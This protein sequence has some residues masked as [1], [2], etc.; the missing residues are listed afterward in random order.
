M[1][2]IQR[3]RVLLAAWKKTRLPK[4][5]QEVEYLESTGTQRIRLGNSVPTSK[6]KFY[7]KL[8]P[9]RLHGGSN[10]KYNGIMGANS[11]PQVGFYAGGWT[12]GI[13]HSAIP[14]PP[15]VGQIY[16]IVYSKDFDGS[17]WVDGYDTTIKRTGN[18][19]LNL[20]WVESQSTNVFVKLYHAWAISN[21]DE[22]L[23]D[24]IPCY[25]KA[26]NKPGLFDLINNT[27]YTNNQTGE[28]I[29]GPNV[30]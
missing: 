5:F 13:A 22:Y 18:M 15:E 19:T 28:F 12:T 16:E 27:F 26:D 1:E 30:N 7:F 17:Y 2:L 6:Y 20:F 4:E 25:R 14:Y 21:T 23:Y 9:T 8:S 11:S 3:R 10:S 29:V 24:I